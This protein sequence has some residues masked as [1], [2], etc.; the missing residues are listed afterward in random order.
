M[1][2]DSITIKGGNI[3]INASGDGLKSTNSEE[4]EKGYIDIQGGTL[5]ITST[6][7]GIQAETM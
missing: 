2:K 3:T 4:T 6:N 7:D 5:N 1:G